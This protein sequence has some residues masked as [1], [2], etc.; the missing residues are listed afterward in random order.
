LIQPA[1]A[2]RAVARSRSPEPQQRCDIKI[3]AF[4]LFS[5]FFFIDNWLEIS[6]D[7]SFSRDGCASS[8]SFFVSIAIHLLNGSIGAR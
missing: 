6:V 1:A 8:V 4:L 5:S 7:N 2:L 3:Q